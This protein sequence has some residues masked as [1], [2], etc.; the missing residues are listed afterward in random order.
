MCPPLLTFVKESPGYTDRSGPLNREVT[1]TDNALAPE[2]L[3]LFGTPYA[4]MWS[5]LN[6]DWSRYTGSSSVSLYVGLCVS[7][8]AAAAL[9]CGH[10]LLGAGGWWPSRYW[11]LGWPWAGRCPCG[12]F[13]DIFPP[14]RY[15]RHPSIFA[16]MAI[17]A[18]YALAALASADLAEL[19]A[20]GDA[21]A[22]R[23]RRSGRAGGR[24]GNRRV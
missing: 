7:W 1:I 3:L 12:W 15:F 16:C 6:P 4:A 18:S 24:G 8:L 10:K 19:C 14:S 21:P 5:L 22:P 11:A 2:C 9:R 17:F 20:L 23:R 13:F